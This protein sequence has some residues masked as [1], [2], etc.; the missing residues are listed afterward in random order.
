MVRHVEIGAD[1][2]AGAGLGMQGRDFGHR[3][4]GISASVP[5]AALHSRAVGR[6]NACA[7]GGGGTG[8]VYFLI[9]LFL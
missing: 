3:G 1:S 4:S 5:F 6:E 7:A 2:W 8:T 9:R